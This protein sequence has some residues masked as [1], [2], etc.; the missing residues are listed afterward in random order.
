MCEACAALP[1]DTWLHVQLANAI[2]GTR[3]NSSA[4]QVSASP[5][6]QRPGW[7]Q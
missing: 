5:V 3:S 4:A 1:Y 7:I 6:C 2:I